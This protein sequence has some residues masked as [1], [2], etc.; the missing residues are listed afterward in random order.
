MH[1]FVCIYKYVSRKHARMYACMH[2][3]YMNMYICICTCMLIRNGCRYV[4]ACMHTRIHDQ[5]GTRFLWHVAMLVLC[6][7]MVCIAVAVYVQTALHKAIIWC[8]HI[9]ETSRLGYVFMHRYAPEN[10]WQNAGLQPRL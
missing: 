6:N 8:C 4:Y 7:M 5:S 2:V 3:L 1:V 9:N 10:Y